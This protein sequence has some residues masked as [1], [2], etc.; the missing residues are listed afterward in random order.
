MILRVNKKPTKAG[1]K[2]VKTE[3]VAAK[4]WMKYR[5][6]E[7]Y[8]G[9]DRTTIWRAVRDGR[10]RQRG[11]PGSPRFEQAETPV[12]ENRRLLPI[13]PPALAPV[14]PYPMAPPA[15]PAGW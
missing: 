5:E 12:T 15:S 9:Y 7:E 11:L 2:T 13:S 3:T 4:S 10:L 1:V 6:A 8:T 14:D